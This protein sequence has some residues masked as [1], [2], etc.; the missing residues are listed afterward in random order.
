MLGKSVIAGAM[1]IMLATL[2]SAQDLVPLPPHP[3]GLAWP[4][5][6]WETGPLP[7]DTAGEIEALVED[8]MARKVG[9]EMGETRSVVIIHH[10]R[11]VLEAY[12]DGFGPETKQV[13]WSMAKSITSA[14]VGRAV[15]LGLIE[16]IDSPMPSPFE[17]GDPRAEITWRQWLTMTDG[18]DYTEIGAESL[19][20]NDV[21]QM[22]YG[23]GRYDVTQYIVSELAPIHAPGTVWNY[24]TAGFHLIGRAL[25]EVARA[26][27]PNATGKAYGPEDLTPS[28]MAFTKTCFERVLDA[29]PEETA[30]P[31]PI[32]KQGP[33][34]MSLHLRFFD[35]IGMDAQPEFDA[36]GTYL[37]G[38]LIWASAR[39]FAKF[40]YLYLRDGVWEGE[41]LLPQGWV[42]FS[43]TNPDVTDANVYGAGWWL[44]AVETPVP[45]AQAATSPPFDVFSAQGFEGQTIWVVPS[46]DLVIVRLGLM[47][48]GE[49]NWP[50]LY[51]WN[52]SLARLF[53]EERFAS[54]P[55]ESGAETPAR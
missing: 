44:G 14:L 18:L 49:G 21:V 30:N 24:S 42:D 4:T 7:V 54:N 20:T 40:G 53:P 15:E 19:Q 43:R 50:A 39:D 34:A 51:E 25:Q 36:A 2:A 48:N 5:D 46:R 23:P 45:A 8:A 10:G 31:L 6:G 22:M 55:D 38:S 3:D 29:S 41:R 37:G 27:P 13:S 28:S 32:M 11:L 17:E 12:A 9:D 47:D 35:E 16:D 33:C 52:Q 26:A 1:A